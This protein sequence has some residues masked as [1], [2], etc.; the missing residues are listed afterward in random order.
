MT[1]DPLWRFAP[2]DYGRPMRGRI[3][4]LGN[5]V[6]FTCAT[7]F[8]LAIADSPLLADSDEPVRFVRDSCEVRDTKRQG[9]ASLAHPLL[10]GPPRRGTFLR[11]VAEGS[12]MRRR[13]SKPATSQP[14]AEEGGPPFSGRLARLGMALP[15]PF[16]GRSTE[17]ASLR[18]QLSVAPL[19][20][21]HGAV[22]SGRR[23]WSVT[24]ARRCPRRSPT[25]ASASPAIAAWRC[26]A[27]ASARCAVC[28]AASPP[29]CRA[30]SASS[31]STTSIISATTTR[32]S[33]LPH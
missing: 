9:T 7:N 11:A 20:V 16:V 31:S 4:A 19:V 12:R 17:L 13:S 3:N 32:R 21:V 30:R 6:G 28:P 14:S 24:S 22:G 27:A 29:R 2:T 8:D 10:I 23:G 25:C 1:V 18:D 5:V 26:A 15:P 33:T